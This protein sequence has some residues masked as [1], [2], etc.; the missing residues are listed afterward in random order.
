[1]D[2]EGVVTYA[3]LK[4]GKKTSLTFEAFVNGALDGMFRHIPKAL[5]TSATNTRARFQTSLYLTTTGPKSGTFVDA[6]DGQATV[7]VTALTQANVEAAL[8]E[9]A[10]Y[11]SNGEPIQNR[12]KFLVV[13]PASEIKARK[14]L[15]SANLIA[16]QVQTSADLQSGNANIVAQMGINLIV[17]PW[18]PV[19]ATSKPLSWFLVADP[20]VL[21]AMEWATLQG[22]TEAQLSMQS[23]NAVSLGG[24]AISPFEGDYD[25][26]SMSW[27]VRDIFGGAPVEPRGLWGSTGAGS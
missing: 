9:M 14:I 1:M 16:T 13:P 2:V 22:H 8:Q 12:A 6:S 17:D 19:I 27:R 21:P 20:M 18:I 15:T 3:A 24:G 25:T 4:Y 23:S 26:D 11:T 7:A 10:A 5:A